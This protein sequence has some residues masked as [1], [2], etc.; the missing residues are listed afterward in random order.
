MKAV[1]QAVGER[2]VERMSRVLRPEEE[3][4]E[5]EWWEEL[6]E[7]GRRRRAATFFSRRAR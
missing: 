5:W 4:R 3:G 1:S 7:E 6:G 2:K